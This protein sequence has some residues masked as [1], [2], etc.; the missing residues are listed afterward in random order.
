MLYPAELQARR[1]LTIHCRQ[2]PRHRRSFVK[3]PQ[4]QGLPALFQMM[5]VFAEFERSMIVERV[6]SGLR[7]AVAQG[8]KLGR[9]RVDHDERKVLKLL[10][11]GVGIKRTAR[12]VGVG[13]ATVQRIKAA[14]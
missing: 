12:T 7:R 3:L 13:V 10:K 1:P 8:K 14:S 4:R 6:K 5:G 11:D 9:P 2:D